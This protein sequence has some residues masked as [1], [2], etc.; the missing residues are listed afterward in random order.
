MHLM[1]RLQE[2][3]LKNMIY[4]LHR[5][6]QVSHIFIS[7]RGWM[8]T[9][10]IIDHKVQGQIRMFEGQGQRNTKGTSWQEDFIF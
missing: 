2:P 1:C 9:S 5:N 3:V 8:E 7:Y 10:N 4:L 6:M